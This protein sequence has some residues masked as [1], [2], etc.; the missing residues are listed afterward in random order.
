MNVLEK[1]GGRFAR[2]A[3]VL[4]AGCL[5]RAA[6]AMATAYALKLWTVED[7]LPGSPVVGLTQAGDGY[8]WLVTRVQ[9]VRFNG[10]EFYDVP[11][12]S[13]V[14]EQ[15]GDLSG[16]FCGQAQGVW[17]YGASGV[18][19]YLAG[20]W[21]VWSAASVPGTVGHVLGM[22]ETPDGVVCAVAERG[23]LEAVTAE[24]DVTTQFAVKLCPVPPDDRATLGAVTDA[25]ADQAGS[26]WMTA[27]NGLV[28]YRDGRFDDQSMRLPD[29]LV[30]AADGVHAG[31]SGRLWVYG[32]NGVAYREKNIW[33][34]IGFPENAGM[35][36]V[37]LEVSD[38]GLW[39]GNPTG[40][41]RWAA[42]RWRRIEEQDTPGSLSVNT[43]IE[44]RDGTLWAACDGGL[45]RIRKKSVGT[46]V[47]EGRATAG[48]AYALRRLAD[49]SVWVGYKGRAVR[50]TG[51][52]GRLLQTLYLDADVPVSALL[53]DA[54]GRVW[55]GTLG[56]G[57]FMYYDGVLTLVTQSDYSMPVVHTVFTLFDDPALG[58]L[59]GTPQG[60]MRVSSAGELEVAAIYGL[61]VTEPVHGLH[62]DP[63]GTLWLC[64]ERLGLLRIRP[65]GGK[66]VIGQEA[67][68]AGYPRVVTRDTSGNLWVG[69]TAGLFLVSRD[70]VVP[71][72]HHVGGFDDAVLQI[73]EDAFGRLWLG[74]TR[75]LLCVYLEDLERLARTTSNDEAVAVRMLHL[76]RSDGVPGGR[77]MGG[78]ASSG[79]PRRGNIWFPF[80]SGVA[81]VDPAKTEFSG[82]PPVV[83]IERVRVNGLPVFDNAE[84]QPRA[85]I[86]E[87][88]ARNIVFQFAALKPGESDS[89]RFRYRVDGVRQGWSPVQAENTAVFEWLPPGDYVLQVVAEAGGIWNLDGVSQAFTVRAY[90]WQTVWFY[91]LLAVG[92]AAVVFLIARW[93]LWHRYQLQMALLKR[94]EALALER[95]R[96]SRDI[97]DEL[98]NGLSVVATLSEL[99][100][101]DVGKGTVHKRLDQIYEVANELARNVDETVWAVNPAND[102]WE[103]FLSYFEQ[104]TEYFLGNSGLRFHFTRPSELVERPIASKTRH[105]LLL[106]VREA[107]GNVLKHA[108]A[109]QVRIAM[110]LDGEV[111]EVQVE[112]D[113]VG[114]D[115]TRP[116]GVGHDGLGNMARRMKEAGGTL[117]IQ[118]APGQ[119]TCVTFRVSLAAFG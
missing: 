47:A 72:G 10:V 40:M 13:T 7:R 56:G 85:L 99:A 62:R 63:D 101:N 21:Q 50:L 23:L 69:T 82:R 110:R 105:H 106:A 49:D 83:T 97:H 64:S 41:F 28:E 54:A 39:I 67:G 42:G 84:P 119:G 9:L 1:R 96:I 70:A 29:F 87:P 77:C 30:E 6:P 22:V 89:V 95:A 24:D 43:L 118:S 74:T 93:M 107:V 76:G 59:A 11:V 5:L 103:P 3:A 15:T 20:A 53:Q 92:L 58:I 117:G 108:S 16:V 68:L 45:L 4:L 2:M 32:P 114:F 73:A 12:P 55:M 113:G 38:G 94:E 8:L 86:L 91:L 75:G 71:I 44:D 36:T 115:T 51:K 102:G 112:D 90:F 80:E 27:W 17:I 37:M 65:D 66:L 60:L 25:A 33:T 26:I 116:A 48:T 14:R 111:L 34:P 57:L 61:R 78:A 19:R 109:K 88:G 81:V 79:G 104:Y 52:E 18:A 31:R 35:A 98:G 46:L 100:H